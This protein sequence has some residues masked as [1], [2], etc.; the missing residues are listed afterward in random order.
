V[1]QPRAAAEGRRQDAVGEQRVAGS[2]RLVGETGERRGD[3]GAIGGVVERDGAVGFEIDQQDVAVLEPG[4]VGGLPLRR[5]QRG[6]IGAEMAMRDLPGAIEQPALLG[7]N[8]RE[9]VA[10]RRRP[11]LL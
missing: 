8:A 1:R 2:R 11:G 5:R 9:M 3:G 4:E 6:G 7:D 10:G